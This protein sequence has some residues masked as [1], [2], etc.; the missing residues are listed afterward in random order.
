M[1]KSIAIAALGFAAALSAHAG[2]ISVETWY[3]GFFNGTVGGA[4]TGAGPAGGAFNPG[5]P[6]WTFTIA[7]DYVLSVID[8]CAVGDTFNVF[9]GAT[10]LGTTA[11]GTAGNCFTAVDCDTLPGVGRGDFL[12]SA[13]SYSISMTV[14]TAVDSG[15][16]FFNVRDVPGRV[17]EPGTLAL[18]GLALG[19]LAAARR[20][21]QA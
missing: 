20:R 9:N 4:V 6:A 10:L 12:L 13:G 8:C 3:L 11:V 21:K 19:G 18:A 15:N 16:L 17:P 7:S 14:A 2:P 5:A 1:K